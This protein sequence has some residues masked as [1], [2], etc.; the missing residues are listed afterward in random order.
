MPPEI[1]VRYNKKRVYVTMVEHR[2]KMF[3]IFEAF[4]G[5][6]YLISLHLQAPEL[7]KIKHHYGVLYRD[8]L[9]GER[10]SGQLV[11]S[12]KGYTYLNWI[13]TVGKKRPPA[14]KEIYHP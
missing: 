14:Y 10:L 9:T 4:D 3:G 12:R 7:S 13:K 11:V 2:G 1:T 8:M 5:C 6:E